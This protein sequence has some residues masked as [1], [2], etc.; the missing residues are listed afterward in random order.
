MLDEQ[1]MT[2][3]E[4]NALVENGNKDSIGITSQSSRVYVKQ[5]LNRFFLNQNTTNDTLLSSNAQPFASAPYHVKDSSQSDIV[6]EESNLSRKIPS[7]KRASSLALA[8]DGT[9][10]ESI[11][12]SEDLKELFYHIARVIPTVIACRVS[13]LQKAS[14][15]RLVK[16]SP[17]KPITLAI[18][19]KT[20]VVTLFCLEVCTY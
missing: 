14:L 13:P 11:W 20:N 6:S 7:K 15:V 2:P 12:S 10:L 3:E 18:G 4:E 16:T 9:S 8:V 19:E 1:Y 17:G 5:T